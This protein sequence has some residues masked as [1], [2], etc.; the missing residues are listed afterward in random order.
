M[1]AGAQIMGAGAQADG[2]IGAQGTCIGTAIVWPARGT[3]GPRTNDTQS[4]TCWALDTCTINVSWLGP[5]GCRR[6]TGI[7]FSFSR[8]FVGGCLSEF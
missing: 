1:G 5:F 7:E 2:G 8:F 4:S 6:E 3:G